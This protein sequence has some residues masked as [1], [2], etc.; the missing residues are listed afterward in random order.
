MNLER[1]WTNIPFRF[2][3]I[4]NL[5]IDEVFVRRLGFYPQVE[6]GEDFRGVAPGNEEL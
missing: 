6:K 2:L 3:P 1:I 5:F 4:Q